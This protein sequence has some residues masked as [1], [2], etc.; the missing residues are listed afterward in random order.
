MVLEALSKPVATYYVRCNTLKTSPDELMRKLMEKGLKVVRHPVIDE[1]LGISIEGPLDISPAGK[2]IVVDKHTAESILQGANLYAPGVTDCE[3]VHC[4]DQVTVVS[5]MGDVLAAGKS[6]MSTDEILKFRKGLAVTMTQRKYRAPQI[7]ELSEYSEG[8]LYPQSLAAMATSRA[9]DPQSGETIVDMNCAP[10]G[11]L[12]HISQLTHNTG[13]ILGLDR[14]GEKIAATRRTIITLGCSNATV[15]IHDSRYA[16]VDF[17]DMKP[18]R[19]IVDPPCSAL[20]LRPKAYDLTSR[21]RVA[22]LANYQRQFLRAASRLVKPGG[23]VV[24]S[25]CTYTVEECEGA[26]DY[27]RHECGLRLVE[28][29]PFLA[30]GRTM[31][32]YCQR[33]HPALDEIGYFIAKFER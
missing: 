7:R 8:L 33:F 21:N 22:S 11:K 20:G 27:A 23:I 28:Q 30:S 26:V 5:E 32:N 14:N 2:Q 15:S 3:S 9:L 4:G 17:T 6:N 12:T 10:G 1:A 13:K 16:D 31:E 19:V 24:Y 25:V 29:A 18:D